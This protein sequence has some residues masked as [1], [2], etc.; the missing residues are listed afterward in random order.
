MKQYASNHYSQARVHP[1]DVL[2]GLDFKFD[3]MFNASSEQDDQSADARTIDITVYD[4][5][6]DGYILLM[7]NMAGPKSSSQEDWYGMR[8][9]YTTALLHKYLRDQQTKS[10]W[11]AR[12]A[13]D[14]TQ[15]LVRAGIV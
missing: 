13:S 8:H 4:C 10:P 9:F 15:L 5:G 2:D 1:H 3:R 12:V 11:G 14:M 7:A 6:E